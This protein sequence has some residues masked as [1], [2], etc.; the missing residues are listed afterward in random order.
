MSDRCPILFTITHTVSQHTQQRFCIH[1]HIQLFDLGYRIHRIYIID[2]P[3]K[4]GDDYRS[5]ERLFS[6]LSELLA[7]DQSV[8]FDIEEVVDA[9]IQ[10]ILQN[11]PMISIL[12]YFRRA[13]VD[14]MVIMRVID[15]IFTPTHLLTFY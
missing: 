11:S 3:S 13:N 6:A 8:E 1:L 10:M 15:I 7:K 4:G 5:S 14:L 12:Q 2:W 9:P